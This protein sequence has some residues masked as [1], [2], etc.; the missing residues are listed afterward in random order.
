MKPLN[1]DTSITHVMDVKR[2]C[3]K[4]SWLL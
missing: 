4:Q 2:Q 3:R 1:G